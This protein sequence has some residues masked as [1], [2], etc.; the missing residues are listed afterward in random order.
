MVDINFSLIEKPAYP[1][2]QSIIC[3]F[4]NLLGLPVPNDTNVQH[5][6]IHLRD[7]VEEAIKRF[8]ASKGMKQIRYQHALNLINGQL[9]QLDTRRVC[10]EEGKIDLYPV[11]RLPKL[12]SDEKSRLVSVCQQLVKNNPAFQKESIAIQGGRL[13]PGGETAYVC[14]R[15]SSKKS[16]SE[17]LTEDFI[18]ITA[19]QKRVFVEVLGFE[20]KG[21]MKE[22]LERQRN[23]LQLKMTPE[24]KAQK[25]QAFLTS[26]AAR[27]T[28]LLDALIE[29]TKCPGL[30]EQ[31]DNILKL[32]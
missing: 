17:W 16:P 5:V 13:N 25:K 23:R 2:L 1:W 6:F 30:Q 3:F 14:Y 19:E 29:R 27:V 12:S 31:K 26:L 20:S 22:E 8:D 28:P 4:L 18:P 10:L 21:A 7:D 11:K 24:Y 15:D 32:F 9:S